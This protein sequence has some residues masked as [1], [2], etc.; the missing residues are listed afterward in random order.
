MSDFVEHDGQMPAVVV[1]IV[2]Y[3]SAAA[4]ERCL[5]SLAREPVARVAVLE[6]GTSESE[7]RALEG[8]AARHTGVE[9]FRSEQNLGFGGGV[10]RLVEL[11]EPQPHDILWLLNPD[12]VVALGTTMALTRR[13]TSDGYAVVTPRILTGEG[14]LWLDS[15][16]LDRSRGRTWD[17]ASAG[18]RRCRSRRNR[19]RSSS[20]ARA[21]S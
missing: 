17:R 20:N 1:L 10:N 4:L 12:T 19:C 16:E 18:I 14:A 7:W 3:R 8:I 5:E 13:V 15:G 9:L 11:V 21:R 6:N 2:N